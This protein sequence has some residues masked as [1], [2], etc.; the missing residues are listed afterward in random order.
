MTMQNKICVIV[1]IYNTESYVKDCIN[2]ILAQTFNDLEILLIDDG[3][4]DNCGKI[5]DEYAES[6]DRIVVIHQANKGVAIARNAGID[7]AFQNSQ[8]KYLCFVDSDD[9]LH[10]QAFAILND[11]MCRNSEYSLISCGFSRDKKDLSTVYDKQNVSLKLDSPEDYYCNTNSNRKTETVMWAK[12]YDRNLFRNIRFPNV[13]AHEDD[14]VMYKILF[15]QSKILCVDL[16]LYYHSS[17]PN[18]IMRS[19]WSPRHLVV[20]DAIQQRLEFF[21]ARGFSRAKEKTIITYGNVLTQYIENAVVGKKYPKEKRM[22]Q[23]MLRTHIKNYRKVKS[24]SYKNRAEWY[25]A[26]YVGNRRI[27]KLFTNPIANIRR[28]IKNHN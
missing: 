10:P 16:P 23:K 24:I 14:F 3:S 5:C 21:G 6:D 18:G 8:A 7:W 12:I 13:R 25:F 2:S 27:T 1:P 11:C 9:R 28:Y 4:T 22:M 26:A 19:E 17:N 20:F 15:S